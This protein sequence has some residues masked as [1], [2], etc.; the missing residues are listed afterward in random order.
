MNSFQIKV[1]GCV[2]ML[3]DHSAIFFGGIPYM[4]LV[5]HWLGRASAPLFLFQCGWSCAHTHN[6][7][8]YALRLYIASVAMVAAEAITN[9]NNNIFT[10]LLHVT[11]LIWILSRPR[12]ADRIWGIVGYVCWQIVT[13][14][15]VALVIP[16]MGYAGVW[17]ELGVLVMLTVLGNCYVIEG[18]YCMVLFGVLLWRF[19]DSKAG[20]A[21]AF[22]G[23]SAVMLLVTNSGYTISQQSGMEAAS[24]VLAL[25]WPNAA[26]GIWSPFLNNYQ[27]MMALALPI[28]LSFTGERGKPVMWFFYVFY[29]AHLLIIKALMAV[30]G[31]TVGV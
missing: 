4:S 17:G 13:T 31:V 20:L 12:L 25:L 6:I 18:G 21:A 15:L 1:L 14:A 5:M 7:R 30:L 8:R 3:I 26:N 16:V 19:R 24:A 10:C 22:V 23:F 28:L 2:L 11:V 9:M 29:P 27:W